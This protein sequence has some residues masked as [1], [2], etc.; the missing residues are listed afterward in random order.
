MLGKG[1]QQKKHRESP[2][3]LIVHL[4][5]MYR[6]YV[7]RGIAALP[8]SA[9]KRRIEKYFFEFHEIKCFH[10][11]VEFFSVLKQLQQDNCGKI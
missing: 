8:L 9:G 3:L 10:C 2:Q 11:N 1:S 5:A 7:Y 6:L 4:L